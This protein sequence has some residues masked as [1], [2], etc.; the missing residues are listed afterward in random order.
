MT[1]ESATI[2]AGITILLHKF[3]EYHRLPIHRNGEKNWKT[4]NTKQHFPTQI[5]L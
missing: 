2:P 3:Q 1:T 5:N 4:K